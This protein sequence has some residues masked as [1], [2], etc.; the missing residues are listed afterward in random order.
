MKIKSQNSN[1]NKLV[2][3]GMENT[4]T[5]RHRHTSENKRSQKILTYEISLIV[6]TFYNNRQ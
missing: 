3:S 5:L 1:N 6:Y 2:E 4:H